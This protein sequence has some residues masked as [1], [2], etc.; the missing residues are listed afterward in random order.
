[1]KLIGEKLDQDL[2]S[3]LK[4]QVQFSHT[5]DELIL[6]ANQLDT[7][8]SIASADVANSSATS[9]TIKS[10]SYTTLHLICENGR[11]FSHWINLERQI[12]QKKLDMLFITLN[13]IQQPNDHHQFQPDSQTSS[14]TIGSS[15]SNNTNSSSLIFNNTEKLID[16]IWSCKYADVDVMKPSHCAETFVLMIKA[17]TGIK[18]FSS[19][20]F[21]KY[22]QFNY[23][24][25][26]I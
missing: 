7:Y 11:L 23:L 21:F 25:R 22:F 8:L 15:S 4:N 1:M 12:C 26:P 9:S 17:I 19:L 10:L 24:F 18:R 3:L 6:F 14:P 13:R 20:I 5:I 16:E 2:S